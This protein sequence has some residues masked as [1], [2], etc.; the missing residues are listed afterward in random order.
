MKANLLKSIIPPFVFFVLYLNLDFFVFTFEARQAYLT[1]RLNKAEKEIEGLK[2]EL[3]PLAR[4]SELKRHSELEQTLETLEAIKNSSHT[5][6]DKSVNI[7]EEF[8]ENQLTL[9]SEQSVK[10]QNKSKKEMMNLTKFT[11]SG[12]Y[13]D[14]IEMLRA[15]PGSKLIPVGFTLMGA[16]QGNTRYTISIWKKQ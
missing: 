13:Q 15:F 11:L 16:N 9:H 12:E 8:E 2:N 5:N 7:Y 6:A 14:V 3:K 10:A 4:N 1:K